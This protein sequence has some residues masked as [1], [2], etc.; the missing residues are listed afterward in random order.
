MVK[1][2]AIGITESLERAY[3]KTIESFRGRKIVF[4]R[5]PWSEIADDS[6]WH[7]TRK[8]Y[9][10]Y[11]E[12]GVIEINGVKWMIGKGE[13][14][15]SYPGDLYVADLMALE[16]KEDSPEHLTQR[17]IECDYFKGTLIIGMRDG[18]F[19]ERENSIGELFLRDLGNCSKFIA[20]P[21]QIDKDYLTTDLRPLVTS[22]TQYDPQFGDFLAENMASFFTRVRCV[23][24]RFGIYKVE[25]DK[26]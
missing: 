2:K 5:A 22:P 24:E 25:G 1:N 8:G 9:M 14:C 16:V 11:K 13:K 3:S 15:G 21:K 26:K 20:R 4:E 17:I 10:K 23:N 12:A 7:R 6:D 19:G 18:S